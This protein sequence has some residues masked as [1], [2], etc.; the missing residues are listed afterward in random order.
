MFCYKCGNELPEG[1]K[2]CFKCGAAIGDNDGIA[3]K[4]AR[5]EKREQKKNFKLVMVAV[6]IAVGIFAV[7][8][9]F[10]G[11]SDDSSSSGSSSSLSSLFEPYEPP[12][13]LDCLTCDG[14]GDCPKCN[15]YGTQANYAGAGDYVDSVCS[16]CHGSRTCPT[17]GGS[18]KR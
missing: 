4:K 3:H 8:S 16:R 10:N 6:I 1:A 9:L 5:A 7:Q 14:D 11:G 17:C 18:G 13:V 12:K 15:G 2:F